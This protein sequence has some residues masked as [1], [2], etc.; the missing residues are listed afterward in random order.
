MGTISY[1]DIWQTYDHES[2]TDEDLLSFAKGLFQEGFIRV[3]TVYDAE[4]DK[5]VT[6]YDINASKTIKTHT[7]SASSVSTP[8]SENTDD[9]NELDGG[10]SKKK[11]LGFLKL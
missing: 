2:M 4:L 3:S 7:K 9:T 1:F 11:F 6:R 8:T 10:K 5:N